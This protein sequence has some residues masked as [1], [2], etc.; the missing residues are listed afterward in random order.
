[1]HIYIKLY[2]H[3]YIY[4]YVCMYI[5]I[6]VC[7]CAYIHIYPEDYPEDSFSWKM[8]GVSAFQWF[9]VQCFMSCHSATLP[10]GAIPKPW[11][12]EHVSSV[13][14]VFADTCGSWR[15]FAG[16]FQRFRLQL[17]L[18]STQ[19]SNLEQITLHIQLLFQKQGVLGVSGVWCQIHRFQRKAGKH[20][21]LRNY[22]DFES[23]DMQIILIIATYSVGC[24]S[25]IFK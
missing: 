11:E 1:M 17:W 6:Y 9:Q 21:E 15:N 4:I 24:T 16:N 3:T 23:P 25:K 7:V 18:C 20:R 13:I 12:S 2:I 22:Q 19:P 14:L 5:Y 8:S 10:S